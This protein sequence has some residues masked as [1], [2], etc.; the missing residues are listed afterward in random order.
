MTTNIS[1]Q[2]AQRLAQAIDRR[3]AQLAADGID[4]PGPIFE[5]M[6]PHLQD[7]SRIYESTSDQ[8]LIALCDEFQGFRRYAE[9][10]EEAF[11]VERQK[12]ARAYDGLPELPAPLK[13][14]LTALMTDA[15]SLEAEFHAAA[16]A[17]NRAEKRKAMATLRPMYQKWLT[18]RVQFMSDV[19]QSQPPALIEIL[20]RGLSTITE[21]IEALQQLAR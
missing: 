19:R 16:H 18:A 2:D 15:A 7:L 4:T 13:R 8:Q 21:R 3:M 17:A 12:P 10:A 1:I 14:A 9:I 5:R 11:E 6:A 20:A